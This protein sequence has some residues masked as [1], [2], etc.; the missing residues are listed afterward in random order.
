MSVFT[1]QID[2]VPA[3]VLKESYSI[4]GLCRHGDEEVNLAIAQFAN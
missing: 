2:I 4:A 1:K 3:I